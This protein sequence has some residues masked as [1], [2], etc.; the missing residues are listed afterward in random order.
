MKPLLAAEGLPAFEIGIGVNSGEM[1]VGNMGSIYRKAYTVLGDSVNLASRL[2]CLTR[3]YGVTIIVGEQTREGQGDYLFR[4]L[5][6]VRV[7]GRS[8]PETLYELVGRRR[9]ADAPLL[10]E[11]ERHET[12]MTHYFAVEWT[13]AQEILRQLSRDHP[14]QGFNRILLERLTAHPSGKLPARWDG[15]FNHT[16]K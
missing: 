3:Y 5:D 15:V 7:K 12:A 10:Q 6:R 2:E 1:N 13:E 8:E 9:D 11:L 4:R 14:G 16:S